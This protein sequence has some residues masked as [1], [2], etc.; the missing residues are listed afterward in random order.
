MKTVIVDFDNTFTLE[1]RDVDDLIALL[2]LISHPAVYV[3]FVCTTFGNGTLREV[4]HCTE[5]VFRQLNLR[6]PFYSGAE[7]E[8]DV[9]PAAQ[10]TAAYLA[11]HPGQVHLLALGSLRNFSDLLRIDPLAPQK[12]ASFVAMGGITETLHFHGREIP[13]L[14]FSV[15]SSA[16][17]KVLQAFRVPCVLTGNH[18]LDHVH[19]ETDLPEEMQSAALDLIRQPHL[20]WIAHARE[21]QDQPGVV[22]WDVLAAMYITEP[23]RFTDHI[24]KYA[25]QPDQLSRGLFV[26][27]DAGFAVNT[28]TLAPDPDLY[29]NLFTQIANAL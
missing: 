22:L 27:D 2:Y 16:A 17:S 7:K 18:C 25:L 20:E 23:R 6:I 15:D 28:P 11:E 29:R 24:Q 26:A 14:N 9:N 12:A 19:T 5:T 13:E 4:N 1:G 3:P 10:K 21:F 8:G